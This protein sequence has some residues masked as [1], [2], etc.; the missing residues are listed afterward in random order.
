MLRLPIGAAVLCR[1]GIAGRLKYVVIDP[2]DT[3]ITDLIVERG[4]LRHKDIVVPVSWVEQAAEDSITLNAQLDDLR[5]LPEYREVEFAMPDPTCKPVCG[6]PV[7]HTRVWQDPYLAAGGGRPHLL[8]RT[9]LGVAQEEVLL[10]R[11]T[12]VLAADN[13]R[14]GT[15]D[16]LVVDRA[17]HQVTQLVVRQGQ[18]LN[19]QARIVQ[20]EQVASLSEHGVQ[21]K[22][23]ADELEHQ[24]PYHPPAS[25]AQIAASLQRALATNPATRT[26]GAQ[27]H[28]RGGVV[29]LTGAI[30]DEFAEAARALARRIRGVIGLEDDL[31]AAPPAPPL[32]VGTSVYGRDWRYG[33]L[34]KVIVDPH[35]RRV[36]H[37]VVR[38]SRQVGEDR[39]IP[40]EQVARVDADSIHLNLMAADL[41]RFPA[42]HAQS[43]AMP[44]ADWEPLVAYPRD[45]TRFW[46]GR[47]PGVTPPVQTAT[48]H[49]I[50]A[51]VSQ[52]MIALWRGDALFYQNEV[53]AW[54]DHVLFDPATA[55]LTHLIAQIHGS[56][57]RVIVPADWVDEVRD[58]AVT[59]SRW[60]PDRPGV[61]EYIAARDDSAIAADLGQQLAHQPELRAVQVQVDR[62]AVQLIGHVATLGDKVT[63][64]RIAWATVGVVGVENCLI[65]DSMLV[66]SVLAEL[67]ADRHTAPAPLEVQAE[68]GTVTLQGLVSSAEVK[69]V[70]EEIARRVAGVR[71]VVNALEV[72]H[73]K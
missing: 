72:G 57:R 60:E 38:S 69:R 62:G 31:A 4:F 35:A 6:H 66:G 36:T 43:F 39:V 7:E 30:T 41:E 24:P 19:R 23:A 40:I 29:R 8:H 44:T 16:H 51:N 32:R 33:W 22:L 9:R 71:D 2:D 73:P 14:I 11:G 61:P 59:L 17:R 18:L 58:G 67:S 13:T 68:L 42:Y 1:D 47:Y 37:L 25:D 63:A 54:L 45:E 21:L 12:P 52:P 5:A 26:S 49:V 64:E 50:P 65:A 15:I 20:L 28:V 27:V 70:A 46:G 53:V 56:D 48:E 3:E 34:D 55:A 10:R